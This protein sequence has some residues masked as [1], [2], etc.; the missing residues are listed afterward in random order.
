MI[1]A[2]QSDVHASP[3]LDGEFDAAFDRQ[4]KY[5]GSVPNQLLECRA[6]PRRNVSQHAGEWRKVILLGLFREVLS[7]LLQA[8]L[9]SAWLLSALLLSAL[10]LSAQ[11]W[12][13]AGDVSASLLPAT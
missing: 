11:L 4:R 7:G 9:L 12:S 8:E 10:L 13:S 5:P 1:P 6:A 2:S 3:I